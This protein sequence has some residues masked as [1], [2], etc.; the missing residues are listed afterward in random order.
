[1]S[2][3][4][5]AQRVLSTR[6]LLLTAS[7][8]L[9][10]GCGAEDPAASSASASPASSGAPTLAPSPSDA[11][12]EPLE[13]VLLPDGLEVGVDAEA[14]RLTFGQTPADEVTQAL[15][16]ALGSPGEATDLPDC[17][18]GPR[19]AVQV[20]GLSVLFDGD[21]FVGWTDAGSPERNSLTPEGLGIQSTLADLRSAMPGLTVERS[22]LGVEWSAGEGGLS[23]LLD[24]TQPTSR[25]TTLSAGET[26]VF[27]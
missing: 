8:V 3:P 13:V 26:C 24:G 10:A 23:G 16:Q 2:G 27:R 11:V 19:S 5:C 20:D 17:G 9:L 6:A 18:Q 21:A 22:T 4:W 25:V 12:A 15:Q 14:T 1:M 7:L